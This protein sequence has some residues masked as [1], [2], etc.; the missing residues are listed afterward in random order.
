MIN[1]HAAPFLMAASILGLGFGYGK[2][3]LFDRNDF[4]RAGGIAAISHSV[5]EDHAFSKAL[6]RIGL[7]TVFAAE[8]VQQ[9]A[10]AKTVRAVWV[11]QLRW[12][13]VRRQ[14]EP[15]AFIL[16]PFFS[17]LSA[18][19]VGAIGAPA[20]GR[21]PWLIAGATILLWLTAEVLLIVAKGWGWRWQSPF[22]AICRELMIPV[23]WVRTLT[24]KHVYWGDMLIDI[25]QRGRRRE[26]NM[27]EQ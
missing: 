9:I 2:I 7:K 8:T 1:G 17:G 10:G 25:R 14:E 24:A 16:E 3:M 26:P 15:A 27:G 13:M 6:A 5:G 11:R 23:L 22:A 20:L 19:I 12:M 18:A 21:S 4:I